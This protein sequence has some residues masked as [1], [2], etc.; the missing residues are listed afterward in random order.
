MSQNLNN[1]NHSSSEKYS[2]FRAT[3]EKD[4]RHS[5]SIDD[6]C[7]FKEDHSIVITKIDQITRGQKPYLRCSLI[8]IF[9]NSSQNAKSICDFIIAER[10]EINIKESTT[11]WHVKV[12]GQLQR[13]LDF[14]D[15]NAITKD[16]ILNYLNSL[17]KTTEEDP[18]NKSIGN[19]NNKKRVLLKYFKWLYNP[20]VD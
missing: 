18:T 20:D 6:S 11:E 15:F 19:R 3:N 13:F 12:L 4:D 17:R 1:A 7:H 9:H 14:K 5:K 10:N 16:D 8:D 2:K